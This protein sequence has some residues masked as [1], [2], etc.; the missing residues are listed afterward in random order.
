ML[1]NKFHDAAKR[2]TSRLAFGRHQNSGPG[3]YVLC[4]F[5]TRLCIALKAG[6]GS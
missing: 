1:F 5:D 3:M 2:Q 6:K 4:F